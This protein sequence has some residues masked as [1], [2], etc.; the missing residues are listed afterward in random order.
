MRE[1]IIGVFH[2]FFRTGFQV[3]MYMFKCSTETHGTPD[4]ETW[5]S[6]I[7]KEVGRQETEAY[8]C[9]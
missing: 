1:E 7:T 3:Y 5:D 4:I 9:I 8:C 2:F 6:Q